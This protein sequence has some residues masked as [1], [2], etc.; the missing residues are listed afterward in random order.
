MGF[1]P[2]TAAIITGGTL[3]GGKLQSDAASDAAKAGGQAADQAAQ[4]Q[5][6]A[7]QQYRLASE[8]FRFGG[9]QAINPLLSS[10][11]I[12]PFQMPNQPAFNMQS[13]DVMRPQSDL[14]ARL[15]EL[16]RLRDQMNPQTLPQVLLEGGVAPQ[17]QE[18]STATTKPAVQKQPSRQQQAQQA[19]LSPQLQALQG[20]Y[21][22]GR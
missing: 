2:I 20:L 10:L 13:G 18:G 22:R 5:R 8:P 12:T 1:D 21:G 17:A 9:Q 19:A 15:E 6:E 16:M 11:G 3:I 14:Q 4:V 7:L